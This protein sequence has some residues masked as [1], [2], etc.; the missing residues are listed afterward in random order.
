M[1]G[2]QCP[3]LIERAYSCL[4]GTHVGARGR[5][6]PVFDANCRL[7]AFPLT[8]C[9]LV[10]TAFFAALYEPLS[11]LIPKAQRQRSSPKDVLCPSVQKLPSQWVRLPYGNEYNCPD[12]SVTAEFIWQAMTVATPSPLPVVNRLIQSMPGEARARLLAQCTPEQLAFGD[13][14]CEPGKPATHV[15]FPLTGFISLVATVSGH[16]PIEMGMIG[17]EG[18]LGAPLALGIDDAPLQ[19][20]VQG[21]GSALRMTVPRFRKQL[22]QSPDL[23]RTLDRY[24]YVL[25]EQLSQ[26]AACN[27]FHEVQARLARWLLMT[28][29]RAH[30]EQLHLTHLFLAGMLGVRRSA[31]TI[32]AGELQRR[33]LI[34]YT[35]GQITVRS[36]RGLEQAA[37]ECYA[38]AVDAYDRRLPVSR[39]M[40]ARMRPRSG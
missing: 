33:Q 17:N 7:G 28:H 12:P 36:R 24:L 9:A 31:V 38:D 8:V 30:G 2:N 34:H 1:V 5:I 40:K 35:R 29:D 37:C 19:A 14:L 32:A 39:R 3:V 10:N 6:E 20:V 22:R 16:R 13:V 25:I 21:A 27:A 11:R 18:M 26:T 15:H 4:R 23:Q